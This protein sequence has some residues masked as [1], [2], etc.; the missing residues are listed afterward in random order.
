VVK[1]FLAAA[2]GRRPAPEQVRRHCAER[3]A[4]YK[5]PQSIELRTALP[6]TGSGKIAA[7]L[8]QEE[9]WAAAA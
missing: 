7:R 8:L 2:P 1:A 6:R 3:L 4:G 5:V 9:E